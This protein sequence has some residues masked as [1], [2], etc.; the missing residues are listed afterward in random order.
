MALAVWKDIVVAPRFRPIHIPVSILLKS[1]FHSTIL[2]SIQLV[3]RPSL[4]AEFQALAPWMM[5]APCSRTG[6]SQRDGI[7]Y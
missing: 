3:E 7:G 1:H 2:Q 5:E 6:K 4:S